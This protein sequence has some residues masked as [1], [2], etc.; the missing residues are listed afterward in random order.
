MDYN[1]NWIRPGHRSGDNYNNV[2][3]TVSVKDDEWNKVEEF[4][5]KNRANYTGISL[6]PFDGGTYKQP[7]FE[8][9]PKEVYEKY[10]GMVKDIDLKA[11]LEVE[12]FTTR[13]EHVAC[14]G[15]ACEL[16]RV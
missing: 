11:V 12:D 10:M 16:T 7:P 3:C 4:M 14:A 1:L 5:W 2:S 15:G 6:L 9:C 13:T 8:E